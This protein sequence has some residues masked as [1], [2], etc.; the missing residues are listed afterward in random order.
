MDEKI[1]MCIF[2]GA[3]RVPGK[4]GTCD[5]C[6]STGMYPNTIVE[7]SDAKRGGDNYDLGKGGVKKDKGKLRFDL[8]SPVAT[9][10]LVAIL[11]RG[12]Y[13][14][15]DRNWE[16]G[17][18]WGRTWA[19][20]MRHMF[21]FWLGTDNDPE[22]GLHHLHHAACNLHFLAHYAEVPTYKEYD[23]RPVKGSHEWEAV[24]RIKAQLRDSIRR[25]DEEAWK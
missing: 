23:D 15:E 8:L 21:E 14:Y 12:A 19:A 17:M 1:H 9:M 11:T 20:V 25:I 13:K 6:L 4:L 16:K 18:R 24:Q 7:P 22:D 10:G 2:C 3:N 5:E